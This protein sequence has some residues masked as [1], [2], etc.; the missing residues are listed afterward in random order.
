MHGYYRD[1]QSKA[2]CYYPKTDTVNNFYCKDCSFLAIHEENHYPEN[3]LS[4]NKNRFSE[5][6]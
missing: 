6:C 5:P 2:V 1:P 4:T 3:G